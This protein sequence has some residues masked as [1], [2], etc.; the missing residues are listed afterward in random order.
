MRFSIITPNYNG[1]IFLEETIKSVIA[2]KDFVDIEYIMVDGGSTD[3]SIDIIDKYRDIFAHCIIEKDS[4]PADAINKGFERATGDVVAWLNADDL[5]FPNT[6]ARVRDAFDTAPEAAMC[7]GGCLIVDKNGEEIR[8][9][10]TRFKELF[11]PISSRFTYQCINYISQPALFFRREAALS[12]GKL[13]EDM[14]AAWDYEYILRLWRE[15]TAKRITG[16]PLSTFRWYDQSISGDNFRVQFKE[17]YEAA[18]E[19]AG[20][21]SLQT[22][23]HFLV[24]WGIVGIYSIMAAVR[25]RKQNYT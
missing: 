5:Y 10:I 21:I 1:E 2:Q 19:D 25:E 9:L 24:R 11:F 16:D 17:E 7:F 4:G 13:K 3:D 6:L 20:S 12:A 22:M 14:I 15:G 23:C 8:D 18:K